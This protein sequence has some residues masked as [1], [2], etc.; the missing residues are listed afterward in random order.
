LPQFSFL[1]SNARQIVGLRDKLRS[2]EFQNRPHIMEI[3]NGRNA[4]SPLKA[5]DGPFAQSDPRRKVGDRSTQQLSRSS[6]LIWPQARA[7]RFLRFLP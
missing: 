2:D 6:N 3:E 5:S 1:Q 4:F 7:R